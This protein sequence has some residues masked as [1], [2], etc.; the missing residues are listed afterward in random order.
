MAG[1]HL[2][3]QPD[4]Q[5]EV[6]G[7]GVNIILSKLHFAQAASVTDV[8]VMAQKYVP[9]IRTQIEEAAT[10]LNRFK[11]IFTAGPTFFQCY[12]SPLVAEACLG[13]LTYSTR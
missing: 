5:I 12:P 2:D 8:V 1:G 6:R 9:A 13:S 3:G 10:C 4:G 7:L 11:N